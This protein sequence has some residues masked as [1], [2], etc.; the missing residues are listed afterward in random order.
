MIGYYLLIAS[1]YVYS[2]IVSMIAYIVWKCKSMKLNVSLNNFFKSYKFL[3]PSWLLSVLAIFIVPYHQE[4]G[5][6]ETIIV[7]FFVP[8]FYSLILLLGL[9]DVSK[10]WKKEK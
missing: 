3:F 1:P 6:L 9:Y 7:S 8:V 4:T 5:L 10:D 2:L